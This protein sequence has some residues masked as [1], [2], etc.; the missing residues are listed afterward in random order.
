MN[1]IIINRK[2]KIV[3]GKTPDSR[4]PNPH[5]P[6]LSRRSLWR[7]RNPKRAQ[8]NLFMQNKPN[9]PNAQI[10]VN[11]VLTMDYENVQLRRCAENKPNSKPFQSQS[12]PIKANSNPIQSQFKPNFKPPPFVAAKPLA[13]P[14]RSAVPQ[15]LLFPFYFLLAS[16]ARE[17]RVFAQPECSFRTPRPLSGS[18]LFARNRLLHLLKRLIGSNRLMP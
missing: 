2:S 18:I 7:S 4:P 6:R 5:Q 16:A 12:K 11:C 15:F 8:K 3:N 13:K 1:Y 10:L 9:L 17:F 14:D